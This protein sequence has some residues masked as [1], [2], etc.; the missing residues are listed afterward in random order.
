MLL[1]IYFQ[2]DVSNTL[3]NNENVSSQQPLPMNINVGSCSSST[4]IND[5]NINFDYPSAQSTPRV[6]IQ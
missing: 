3:A 5:A 4:R 2:N 1:L 6:S